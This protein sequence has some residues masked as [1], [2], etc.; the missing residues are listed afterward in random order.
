VVEAVR[1]RSFDDER[2]SQVGARWVTQVRLGRHAQDLGDAYA[3]AA[4]SWC[5]ARRPRGDRLLRIVDRAFRHVTLS[6]VD[7][8]A[9]AVAADD[10]ARLHRALAGRLVDLEPFVLRCGPAV[11]NRYAIELYVEPSPELTAV[12]TRVADAYREVFPAHP[13]APVGKTWRGHSAIAYCATSFDDDGLAG[14]LLR[15]PGAA[16]GYLGPAVSTVEA[17]VLAPTD[18]WSPQGM[19]WDTARART[20]GIGSIPARYPAR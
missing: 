19:W 9:G 8:P 16:A 7:I 12:H 18:A 14:A 5:A 10:L 11:V 20:I 1:V 6:L 4:R 15:A 13:A 3:A 2:W 17:V